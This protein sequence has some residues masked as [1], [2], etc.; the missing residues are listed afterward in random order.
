VDIDVGLVG[1]LLE[2]Q[3]PRWAD[4]TLAPVDSAGTDHA[5][6]RLGA[7]LCVRLPRVD[8]AVAQV[9]KEHRWLPTLAP[10]LPL[11]IP[12]P[13]AKGAPGEGYRWPWSVYRWIEGEQASIERLADPHE[14]ILELARF[15]ASM[16]RVDSAG[17]P[18][19]GAHNFFRGVPLAAREA[20]TRDAIA[21]LRD[22][23]DT[24]AV[25]RAWDQ[26]LETPAWDGPPVWI[27]GDLQ[28]GNLLVRD[29]R[30]TAV[31]D[32]GGLG[33]GDP[34]C[35][36][37]VA[38]NFLP[39]DLRDVFRVALAVDDATWARGRGWALSVSLIALPY[40]QATNPVIVANAIRTIDEVLA[41][42]KRTS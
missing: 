17:G 5:I 24:G 42:R 36:L 29:G 40:Y 1:H 25:T 34:A 39:A 23:A 11:A 37:I 8:W 27:H 18:A 4:L 19:P 33:V 14:A 30:L 3:F 32:F 20:S 31:I 35:D 12:A 10:V 22:T 13:V 9:E 38:W 28:A 2:A 6:Y 15:V 26:A 21:S 41:D 7:E 16:H